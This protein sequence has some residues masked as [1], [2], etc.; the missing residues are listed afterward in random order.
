[1]TLFAGL[2]VCALLAIELAS[3]LYLAHYVRARRKRHEA[4]V[5]TSHF[6]TTFPRR[7]S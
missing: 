1:M 3:V 5:S 2:F 6:P 7:L 4:S